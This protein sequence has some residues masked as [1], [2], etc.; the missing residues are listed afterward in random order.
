MLHM[1]EAYVAR[2][3]AEAPERERT[4][5]QEQIKSKGVT[6]L[7]SALEKVG[8][9]PGESGLSPPPPCCRKESGNELAEPTCTQ[10]GMAN[11]Q[12]K[13]SE[14]PCFLSEN[15]PSLSEMAG[16][17][18]PAENRFT[19]P[20]P[21]QVGSAVS[22]GNPSLLGQRGPPSYMHFGKGQTPTPPF[23]IPVPNGEHLR[24][25][26]LTESWHLRNPWVGV[27]GGRRML[28]PTT[29]CG[30]VGWRVMHAA[31]LRNRRLPKK[32]SKE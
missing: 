5:H 10:Q 22:V 24:M 19:E 6:P 30:H 18:P 11:F 1:K 29:C 12:K 2:K 27:W 23:S 3:Y 9:P 21:L 25:L 17:T 31:E 28:H 8:C 15:P 26:A 32:N 7:D 13:L 4:N 20:S 16:K 14:N